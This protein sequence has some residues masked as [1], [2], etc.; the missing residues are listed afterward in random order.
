VGKEDW[1]FYADKGDGDPISCYKGENL[2]S[3]EQL[4][5]IAQNCENMDA[6]LKEQ[7][8]EFLIFI[9]PNK[10]CI[11]SEYM[12]EQYGIPSD[13]YKALQIVN[14]LRANTDIRVV[15]PYEELMK[16][17]EELVQNIYHRTDTYWNWI[18][19]YVGAAALLSEL[20]IDMPDIA[21]DKITINNGEMIAGD[22]AGML[23][24]TNMLDID[25]EYTVSGY[26]DHNVETITWDINDLFIYHAEGADPRKIYVYR[27]SF[28]LHMS[29]YI[30]S[31][32]SDSYFK[33]R[34]YYSY[35]DFQ[36]Q[37]PDIFVYETVEQYIDG[38]SSFSIQ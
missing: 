10:E 6:F 32:F 7:G 25:N 28:S 31:Q 1:L 20:G 29:T 18:G 15:Y 13:T 11:Y 3:E 16:A 5:A 9:A 14:Y 19:G 17:K 34:Q 35:D 24:L 36:Q 2:L 26:D 22:L 4:Q 27:D 21:G 23:N 8:K 30:G 12:P 33:H 37:N 38:L